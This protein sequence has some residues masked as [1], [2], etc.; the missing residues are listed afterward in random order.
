[1]GRSTYFGIVFIIAV[2][3]LAISAFKRPGQRPNILL[4]VSEDHGPHL[5][6]YGDTVVQTPN[7]DQIAK[8]GIQFNNAYV[9]ESVCSP[10]RSSILTGLYPHQSGHLGLTTH[11]FHFVGKIRTLYQTLKKGGYRT[12]MIGKLHVEPDSI[13]PIDYH[14][15]TSPNYEKLGLIRYAEYAEKFMNDGEE[16]FF[17]M[18]NYPDTHWPF[19]DQVEGRPRKVLKPADVTSFPYL[20]FDNQLIREYST[21]LYNCLLR[22][23]ECVGELMEKLTKTGKANN[24]LVIYLS[25]HGDEMGRGKFDSYEIG[26]KIPL[27]ASWPGHI[28]KNIQSDALVSTVDLLP[29]ILSAAHLPIEDQRVTGKSLLPLFENPALKF[30]KY[31]FTEKNCDQIGMYYPRRTIRDE[32]YKLIYSLLDRKNP[33]AQSY[34]ANVNRGAAVAGSPTINEAENASPLV[35]NIYALWLQPKKVQLYDLKNDPWEYHDL[36]T[37]AKYDQVK[38]NLLAELNRWQVQTDDPLRFPEKLNR[39]T[40]ENDTMKVAKKMNWNYPSYLYGK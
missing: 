14:P 23:D 17:L 20:Q 38:K 5:S 35:R 30:R 40:Q 34:M 28:K 27:L 32:R 1:M 21:A 2:A 19:Q 4:I 18:V 7:L 24:T 6:C 15:I 8:N 22:L 29:T 36:S 9:T 13:F 12:G 37:D 31:L 25:D 3:A 11:G 39:L 26:T 10:S 16:P 33:V